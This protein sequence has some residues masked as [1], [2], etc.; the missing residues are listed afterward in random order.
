MI[1]LSKPVISFLNQMK[2]ERE[3]KSTQDER[4]LEKLV[5]DAVI[6]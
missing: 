3:G 6:T 1:G 5:K 4:P 2:K